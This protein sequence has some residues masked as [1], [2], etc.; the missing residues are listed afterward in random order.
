MS[1]TRPLGATGCAYDHASTESFWSIFK[2][3]FFYRH[4]FASPKELRVW[5][6]RFIHRYNTNRGYSK[7]GCK[8]P[9]AYELKCNQI[10]GTSC[11]NPCLQNWGNLSYTESS[12]EFCTTMPYLRPIKVAFLFAS[13]RTSIDHRI[14]S[15]RFGLAPCGVRWS[16]ISRSPGA[17]ASE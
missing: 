12:M 10:R 2:H 8:T 11:I 14:R 3:E 13:H 9:S 5:I 1:L 4:T 7:I 15:A 16:K 17:I 6:D